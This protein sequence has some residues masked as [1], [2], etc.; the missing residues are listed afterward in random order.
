M[1]N[2]IKK[3]KMQFND[4]HLFGKISNYNLERT[5]FIFNCPEK[6]NHK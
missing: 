4:N 2:E 3:A 6:D 5:D 1:N